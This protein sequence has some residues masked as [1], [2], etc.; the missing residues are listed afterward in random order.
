MIDQIPSA[1][2]AITCGRGG[3]IKTPLGMVSLHHVNPEFFVGY[4]TSAK[5][6]W[7]KIAVPEKALVDILYLRMTS[8]GDFKALP[9][10]EWPPNFKWK[11]A[12]RF[13][14]LTPPSAR[15]ALILSALEELR[16]TSA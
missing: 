13:A 5:I 9:E 12:R 3:Q 16:S 6:S 14:R 7:L 4:D 15:R 10:I 8:L 2:Y 11:M 1:I